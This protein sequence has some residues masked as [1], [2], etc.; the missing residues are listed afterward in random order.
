MGEVHFGNEGNESHE[1][2]GYSQQ[3]DLKAEILDF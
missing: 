1:V 2:F 3:T